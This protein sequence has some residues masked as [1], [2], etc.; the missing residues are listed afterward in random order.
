M[1][2]IMAGLAAAALVLMSACSVPLQSLG[3][4]LASSDNAESRSVTGSNGTISVSGMTGTS[5]TV[6]YT[7]GKQLSYARLFVSEGNGSGLVLASKDMNYSNGVYTYTLTHPTFVSGAKIYICVL[8][9]DSGAE[10][11]VPQGTLSTTTSWSQITY[12]DASAGDTSSGSSGSTSPSTSDSGTVTGANGSIAVSGMTGTSLT[13]SYTA[14]KQLSYAR[15]FVSEGNGSGLVLASKDMNYS[16]GVYTYTLTHPTFVSGAKIYV[17]VLKNDSGA[18]KCVPQGTLA[19]TTSWSQITYGSSSSSGSSSGSSGSTTPASPLVSMTP[20]M[21]MTIQFANNTNGTY[22]NN[23]IY[24]CVI[25]RNAAGSFCYLR[26]DGTLVPITGD[27]SSTSWSYKL[28][29]F[30]GFQVPTTMTSARLYVSMGKPVVMKGVVDIHGNIGVAQPDL[31]NP[32]DANAT[33]I[34]DWI[35]FTVRDGGFWG[36]T[37]QVDQ[38]GLPITM[39]M[40]NDSGSSYVSYRKVGITKSREEIFSAFEKISQTEFRGLVQRPYR[41]VAPCKGAFRPG[42]AYGTYMDSYVNE[43]WSYYATHTL[44]FT[45][46][47][48]T[49]A[50]KVLSDGRFEF[51]RASDGGK[52]YIAKKPDNEA[53]FEGSGVLASGNDTEKA[54]QAQICAAL[55]RH[56]LMDPA[57]WANPS[58]YYQSGPANWFAK[59]WH[60]NNM[61]PKA[62]GFCYDDVADQ[63]SLIETHSSRGLIIGIGW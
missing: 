31:N 58:A 46:P 37:T 43:V 54:I 34:F 23:Q 57:N 3:N 62:Y 24:A 13:V 21:E 6:S 30:S 51:T 11:C 22:A 9:N 42:R 8:K 4:G 39:E 2:R 38:F 49:F 48:G 26:P 5:L 53:L 60:D 44:N 7:A 40:F 61:T 1:K 19:T 29:D 52:F 27:S 33:L 12:G 45:H 35:E 14:G 36:N 28:S 63:S 20:G 18:E 25:G 17:C 10:K 47:L 55:N 32:A 15:L 50:G 56:V 16:N 41:I 59:F